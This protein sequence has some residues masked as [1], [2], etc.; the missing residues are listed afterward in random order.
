MRFIEEKERSVVKGCKE[1]R[2]TICFWCN[3]HLLVF[4]SVHLYFC[5]LV[6]TSHKQ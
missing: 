4:F 2:K 1:G 3:F 6:G 5:K